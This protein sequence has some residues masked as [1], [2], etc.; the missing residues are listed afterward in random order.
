MGEGLGSVGA[1]IMERNSKEFAKA[2]SIEIHPSFGA[3]A[4][5]KMDSPTASMPPNATVILAG[6]IRQ[7]CCSIWLLCQP[8]FELARGHPVFEITF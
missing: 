8:H 2:F 3:D 4:G 6:A 1:I 7:L 5:A